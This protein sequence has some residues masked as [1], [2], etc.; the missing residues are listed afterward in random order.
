MPVKHCESAVVVE[1]KPLGNG[2][3]KMIVWWPYPAEAGQFFMVRGW[4]RFP[5]LSRPISVHDADGERVTFL[6]EVRGEGTRLLSEKKAGEFVELSGPVGNGF[7]VEKMKGKVAVVSGGIGI[8]PLLL[9]VKH[10]SGCEVTLCCGFRDQSYALDD[11]RP[12]VKEIRVATDSGKEGY[13]GF[14]T[15]L[16]DPLDFDVV[17]TCGP[18]MMMEKLAKSCIAKKVPCYVSME[19]HMPA[20]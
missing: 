10:L 12:Y 19:R 5:L 11:F 2:I 6:Y 20:A 17:L 13:K 18:E 3:F 16:I 14:V 7:P 15:D 4:D 1:N 8:A 9:A